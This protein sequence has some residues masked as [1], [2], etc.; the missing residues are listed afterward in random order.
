LSEVWAL[1]AEF[2]LPDYIHTSLEGG[3]HRDTL[4]GVSMR[5]SFGDRVRPHVLFGL[6]VGRTEDAFTTCGAIRSSPSSATPV[7]MLVSCTEPDVT[8][9][10]QDRFSNISLFPLLGAGVEIP[11]G[12][13]V[14]LIPDVRVQIGIGSVIVR[15]AVALGFA[16]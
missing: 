15:P 5:R 7:Q 9:R 1:D 11:L 13:R 12:A 8:A 16:Y 14:R 6:S 4:F 3:R 2:W 10:H